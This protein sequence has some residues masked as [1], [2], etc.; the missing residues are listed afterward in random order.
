MIN[1]SKTELKIELNSGSIQ[2]S[3]S[4]D[5]SFTKYFEDIDKVEEYI[6]SCNFDRTKFCNIGTDAHVFEINIKNNTVINPLKQ[7]N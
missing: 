6:I 5:V 1:L 7:D 3:N 2:I 4:I